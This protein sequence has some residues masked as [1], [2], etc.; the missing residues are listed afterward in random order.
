M[1][2]LSENIQGGDTVY[3]FDSNSIGHL[4]DRG[5]EDRLAQQTSDADRSA[6]SATDQAP[7]L[8]AIGSIS[9]LALPPG[10]LLLMLATSEKTLGGPVQRGP[11]MECDSSSL[12]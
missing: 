11:S 3:A 8:E 7:R 12:S 6:R 9:S 10:K 1:T 4:V 2:A 5:N